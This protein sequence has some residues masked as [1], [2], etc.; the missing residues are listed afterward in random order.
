[1][2]SIMM[3]RD[4]AKVLLL[5]LGVVIGRA[6]VGAVTIAA[7]IA[8][9]T[10]ILFLRNIPRLPIVH[11]VSDIPSPAV[12]ATIVVVGSAGPLVHP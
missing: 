7:P 6:G 3:F 8:T 12:P 2:V 9:L 4:N 10:L 1:M 11:A 5:L